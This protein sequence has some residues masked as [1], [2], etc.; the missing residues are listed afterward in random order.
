M[1]YLAF[2]VKIVSGFKPPLR[3]S[4]MKLPLATIVSMVA[5]LVQTLN[6]LAY[7]QSSASPSQEWGVIL[8]ADRSTKE[9]EKEIIDNTRTL[10][11]KPRTYMCNGW[12]RTIAVYKSRQDA[13]KALRKVRAA[14]SPYSPYIVSLWQWCPGKKL[15]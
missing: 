13:L 14:G 12:V 10:G 5:I 4:S 15:L 1:Y 7:A 2:V 6:L 9:A 3:S 8:G 11:Q